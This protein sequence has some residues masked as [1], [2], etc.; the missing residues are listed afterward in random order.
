MP[1][2]RGGEH[3]WENVAAACRPCNLR[4][5]DRTPDEAGMRLARRPATPRELAWVVVAVGQR[6]RL[7]EA[8]PGP[9]DVHPR[10]VSGANRPSGGERR[11]GERATA[12]RRSSVVPSGV[13]RARACRRPRASERAGAAGRV[14]WLERRS[15]RRSVL[16]STPA[17]LERRS[18][19]A[20]PWRQ[21]GVELVRR[22]SGGGAVLLVPGEVVW[23]DVV[24]PAGDPLWDDDV[25]RAAHWLGAAWAR[26]LGGVRRPGATVHRGPMVRTPWS[27]LVCF[28]GLG[29]GEVQ[30]GGRKVVGI[31][32][33]RTRGWARFQ[34]AV[35]L[36]WDPAA[37]VALL[38]RA[39]APGRRAGRRRGPLDVPDADLRAAF[40]AAFDDRP[41]PDRFRPGGRASS[42]T[43][44][45]RSVRLLWRRRPRVDGLAAALRLA[46]APRRPGRARRRA[47]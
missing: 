10:L 22:R 26:A 1:R 8:V 5:R 46:P 35:Y 28:A 36:R 31:S 20:A 19:A 42:R 12:M 29:P 30:L 37:L 24:V 4:K 44:S 23:V 18:D 13:E 3:I 41:R 25:G 2:S 6:A 9:P 39:P 38:R 7:L 34:C 27:S 45:I 21:A 16:G 14:W 32:Q 43:E 33:R 40:R 47:W 17:R 11:D 15:R